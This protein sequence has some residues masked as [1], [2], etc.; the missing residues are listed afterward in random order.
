M[1]KLVANVDK[2]LEQLKWKTVMSLQDM[3]DSC[4]NFAKVTLD[5]NPE[6][7]DTN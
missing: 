1:P 3:C 7:I 2:A 5:K 4:I 6:N